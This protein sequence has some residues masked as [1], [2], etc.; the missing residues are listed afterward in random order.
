MSSL[1]SRKI[2]K[3]RNENRQL[4]NDKPIM[5]KEVNAY[6]L[7]TSAAGTAIRSSTW[8]IVNP[9]DRLVAGFPPSVFETKHF[10]RIMK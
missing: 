4:Q 6:G 10:L 7:I 8:Q 1:R 2:R 9:I 3:Q 5:R